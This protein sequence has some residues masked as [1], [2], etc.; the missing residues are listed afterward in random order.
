MGY[1]QRDDK[2]SY[3]FLYDRRKETWFHFD[4][5]IYDCFNHYC[6]K[7]WLSFI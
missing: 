6:H 3:V 7:G 5:N 2:R 1:E 4:G